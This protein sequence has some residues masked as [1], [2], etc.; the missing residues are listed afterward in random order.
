MGIGAT[1]A[2]HAPLVHA[3]TVDLEDWY[4]GIPLTA[5]AKAT[6][7]H[8]LEVGTDRLLELLD[9]HHAK[10]TFFVLAPTARHDAPLVRRIVDAGHEIG[11]HGLSHDLLYEMTPAQL[12]AETLEA[13]D[14]IEQTTGER[15][16]S[17]RAAY[18]SIT[19]KNLW[20]FEVLAECGIRYD[21]SV[22]LVRNWR[23]GIPEFS[24]R[25][26]EIDTP[27][28]PLLELPLSTRR[29]HNRNLP[30][31]GGAYFR[32]YPYALSR[33]NM[34]SNEREGSPTVFYIHP[35]EL[36]PSHPRVS[37]DRKAR[38]TH[39]VNLRATER[40]LRRLLHDFE[41]DTLQKVLAREFHRN[42]S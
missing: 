18:F 39:Y 2:R 10:A 6:A 32:L 11:C 12:K 8:R 27:S 9:E 41:F 4:H 15:V 30:A 38:L 28:G 33:S 26:I 29:V 13:L 19:A 23:Y 16:R 35:W 3:F 1:T 25:P 42:G 21:S 17:Y 14:A 31:T 37:F 36:D 7:E 34:L 24:R 22:F 40:R 20:A 5:A